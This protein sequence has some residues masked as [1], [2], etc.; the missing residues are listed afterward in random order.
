MTEEEE[1]EEE[2]KIV[3]VPIKGIKKVYNT[4]YKF[5]QP[6][7]YNEKLF[8]ALKLPKTIK[9]KLDL[10]KEISFLFN[11]FNSIE[12]LKKGSHIKATAI[13]ATSSSLAGACGFIP[14]PF[15]DIAPVIIIQVSMILALAKIYGITKDKYNLKDVILSGGCTL[16][17]AAINAGVQGAMKITGQGFK[18]VFNNSKRDF[19]RSR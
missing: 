10:L 5:L 16:G 14:V 1:D 3:D 8:N 17:D 13:V 4:I 12:D 11:A 15:V 7:I 2:E 6:E 19:K 9:E 18:T